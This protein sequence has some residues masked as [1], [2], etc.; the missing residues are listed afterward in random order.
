MAGVGTPISKLNFWR[1]HGRDNEEAFADGRYLVWFVKEILLGAVSKNNVSVTSADGTNN[2]SNDFGEHLMGALEQWHLSIVSLLS[3]SSGGSTNNDGADDDDEESSAGVLWQMLL[4]NAHLTPESLLDAMENYV[5]PQQRYEESDATLE[6]ID[7]DDTLPAEYFSW[8]SFFYNTVAEAAEANSNEYNGSKRRRSNIGTKYFSSKS[9]GLGDKKK[10][11]DKWW[12]LLGYAIAHAFLSSPDMNITT[13]EKVRYL[14]EHVLDSLPAI[15]GIR[16]FDYNTK[17]ALLSGI[18][19]CVMDELVEWIV[20]DGL[21]LG[22]QP[23]V[24][25]PGDAKMNEEVC[26][27]MRASVHEMVGLFSIHG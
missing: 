3:K 26:D 14:K 10:K 13:Q 21:V 27:G 20:L 6:N 16:D 1:E 19:A 22:E 24:V 5:A 2:E 25:P 8:P 18:H 12:P 15:M 9:H 17:N 4:Q 11:N 23:E 7:E